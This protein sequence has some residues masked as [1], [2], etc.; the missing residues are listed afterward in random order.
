M[1]FLLNQLK[2]ALQREID[3]FFVRAL[4]REVLASVTAAAV[5][6]AR[7]AL[8]HTVFVALNQRLMATV[9]PGLAGQ[10]WHGWRVLAI[11][12]SV[13]NLPAKARLFEALGGQCQNGRQLPMARLSQLWDVGTCLSVHG[14]LT[15]MWLDERAL[16]AL[17]AEHAPADALV[18]LDRGY[19]SYFLFALYQ[20]HRRAVCMRLPR[21]FHPGA[22]AL[23]EDEGAPRHLVLQPTRDGRVDCAGY[24]VPTVP[25]PLRLVR[26]VLRTGEVE[27]LATSLPDDPRDPDADFAALYALRWGVEGD[28]RLLKARLQIENF[29]GHREHV[30]RQDVHAKLLTKNL[31]L[32]L[33]AEAQAR[34]DAT[35]APAPRRCARQH[36]PR[37]NH[38][39][40]LHLRST[41]VSSCS[42]S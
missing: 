40:A 9:L 36:H 13:L 5:C 38:T 7:R 3:D 20:H 24:E 31:A 37:V 41:C 21:G 17:H 18:L 16:A 1:L 11:D 28:F 8:R 10:R 33:A 34:L 19:P 29:S 42:C 30:I 22:D 4:G 39:D 35:A 32:L 27:V 2:G 26:V 23:F 15:P 14:L 6:I 12:G 25:V